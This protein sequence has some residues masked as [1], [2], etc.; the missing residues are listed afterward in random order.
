MGSDE[1]IRKL[2]EIPGLYESV[3]E[4]DE[5]SILL[6][7][8][9]IVNGRDKG[10]GNPVETAI[11]VARAFTAITGRKIYPRDVPMI[12]ILY[13]TLRSEQ[14]YKRDN[15]VDTAGYTQIRDRILKW[16]MEHPNELA[17]DEL[18]CSQY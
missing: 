12:Q 10:Y 3:P 18:D 13:K 4:D 17:Y 6:K 11:R 8:D 9:E 16:E 7:A 15:Q 5:Q 2:K 1:R 14:H